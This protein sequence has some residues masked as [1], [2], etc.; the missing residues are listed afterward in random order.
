MIILK[1]C[2]DNL[3][4]FRNFCINMTYPKKIV[5]T[6]VENEFLLD[7][8][9]FRYKKVNILMGSNATGKTSLGLLIQGFSI[10]LQNG[11]IKQFVKYVNE[12]NK[13]ATLSIDF[14]TEKTILHRFCVT[15]T[16]GEKGTSKI[17]KELFSAEIAPDDSYESCEKHLRQVNLDPT[18]IASHGENL[19]YLEGEQEDLHS[20]C[21][22]KR[23]MEI[24]EKVL[25]T[26]DP[27][28]MR[29][30]Q[31]PEVE[32]SYVIRK[33]HRAVIVQ[34]GKTSEQNL[35]SSGT[36]AGMWIAAF[37][38]A[39]E[40][41][42]AGIFYCDSLFSSIHS[43]IEKACLS[44]MVEKIGSRGQLFFTTHNTDVLDMQ[45]P[46]HSF[47]FLSKD[48]NHEE[49][50]VTCICADDILKRNTDSVRSAAEKDLFTT[51]P[52]LRGIY[53]L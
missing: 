4:A 25:R 23:Y 36:V 7:R 6:S 48:V 40:Q 18:D 50:P 44:L 30:Q 31:L 9:N 16:P 51:Y 22:S 13:I 24:L 42:E 15:I 43:D 27:D 52:D 32:N 26:I 21:S 11:E 46:K 8:P 20:L 12:K 41:A 14:V 45:L 47:L 5:K 10:Y 29:V 17:K 39:M 35:L 2:A 3:F 53:D 38:Y 37:L 28:I 34:D 19:F 33:K 49:N 1:I